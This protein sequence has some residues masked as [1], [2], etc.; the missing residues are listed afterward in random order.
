VTGRGR[1]EPPLSLPGGPGA[2]SKRPHTATIPRLRRTRAAL[3]RRGTPS[4]RARIPRPAL[5]GSALGARRELG[6]LCPKFPSARHDER[7]STVKVESTEPLS[8]FEA[9]GI[10]SSRRR[11]LFASFSK[12]SGITLSRPFSEL[13]NLFSGAGL[14]AGPGDLSPFPLNL[15]TLVVTTNVIRRCR[16]RRSWACRRQAPYRSDPWAPPFR[17][18]CP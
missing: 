12:T 6:A 1:R 5:S 4:K 14:R 9:A 10:N 16:W 15:A 7:A 17:P 18:S 11:R 2:E 3:A 8:Q 13:S